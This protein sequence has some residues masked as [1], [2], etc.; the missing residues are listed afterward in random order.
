VPGVKEP[1]STSIPQENSGT[2]TNVRASSIRRASDG[3]VTQGVEQQDQQR[4]QQAASPDLIRRQSLGTSVYNSRGGTYPNRQPTV[5][6]TNV[7]DGSFDEEL[8]NPYEDDTL[9]NPYDT[10]RPGAGG[11]STSGYGMS[12]YNGLATDM[13]GMNIGGAVDRQSRG[14]GGYGGKVNEQA[15][16]GQ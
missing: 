7:H 15:I 4:P 2:L 9:S 14:S 16:V 12:P 10:Y 11:G 6:R 8:K 5:Q 13:S 1:A 3:Q